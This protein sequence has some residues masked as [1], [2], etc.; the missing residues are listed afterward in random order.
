MRSE[1]AWAT[2]FREAVARPEPELDL[3]ES[4]LLIAACRNPEL[5][6]SPYLARLDDFADVV[7]ARVSQ[8]DSATE[9][10]RAL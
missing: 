9:A 7:R 4:A 8:S 2:Q 6:I 10:V 5:D 1:S 3:A